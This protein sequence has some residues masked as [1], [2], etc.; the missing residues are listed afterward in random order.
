MEKDKQDGL[1]TLSDGYSDEVI[2][3]PREVQSK[4]VKIK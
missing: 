2:N 3:S 1:C 4:K